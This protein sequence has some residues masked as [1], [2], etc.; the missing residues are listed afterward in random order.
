[1][2]TWFSANID[3]LVMLSLRLL[4]AAILGGLV[5]FERERS[6]Q[7]AGFRTHMLVCIGSAL[8]MVTA[9]YLRLKYQAEISIDPT[10]LGAQVISGIGFLGAGTIIRHGSTVRGLTTAAGLW[11]VSCIGL[12]VG[13][14]F[15]EGAVIAT[16]F[17]T[18]T[19][20]LTRPLKRWHSRKQ[21]EAILLVQMRRLDKDVQTLMDQIGKTTV[22]MQQIQIAPDVEGGYRLRLTLRG[23]S[24]QDKLT[25]VQG[26]SRLSDVES[27][28]DEE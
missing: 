21:T 7:P 6:H 1:M 13:S 3:D 25:L 22:E 15:Y 27:I 4:V 10:R 19:L 23:C 9:E 5:G 8:V 28:Q 11:A 12:A 14:G 18:L 24:P 16:L 17:I 2:L 26:I 20:S